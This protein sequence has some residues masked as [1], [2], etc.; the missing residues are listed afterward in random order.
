MSANHLECILA[1]DELFALMKNNEAL[2]MIFQTG[3]ISY[4][5]VH[6]LLYG[7]VAK[8]TDMKKDNHFTFLFCLLIRDPSFLITIR[9]QFCSH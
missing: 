7:N 1:S 4:E 2:D 3:M 9:T 5:L 6:P 8:D